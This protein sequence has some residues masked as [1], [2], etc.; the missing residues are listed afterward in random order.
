M[1]EKHA[2]SKAKPTEQ[3]TEVVLQGN[4]D[5]D[6]IL[7]TLMTEVEILKNHHNELTNILQKE[8]AEKENMC[9]TISQSEG[10]LKKKEA[11]LSIM[12]KKQTNNKRQ[13]SAK[14][15]NNLKCKNDNNYLTN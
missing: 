2:F 9:K 12:E 4:Q 11:E 3:M 6:K 5:V 1:V 7:G 13:P 14:Q 15:P 10:E 8:H